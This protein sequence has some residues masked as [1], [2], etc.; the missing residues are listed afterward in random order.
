MA[1]VIELLKHILSK[2]LKTTDSIA[3]MQTMV[4]PIY[5]LYAIAILFKN[6][7]TICILNN[8]CC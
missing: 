7:L 2:E 4:Y 1:Y 8:F 6:K 3:E 5:L